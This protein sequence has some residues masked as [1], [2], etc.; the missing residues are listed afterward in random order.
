MYVSKQLL[1]RKSD[2]E[3][4]RDYANLLLFGESGTGKTYTLEALSLLLRV[5][6][7]S[8]PTV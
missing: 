6:R 3:L 2:D 5:C 8:A 4:V 7:V 1:K